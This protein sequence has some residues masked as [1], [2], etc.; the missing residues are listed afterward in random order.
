MVE[1][2]LGDYRRLGVSGKG[3]L[4]VGRRQ[5]GDGDVAR[6]APCRTMTTAFASKEQRLRMAR[7]VSAPPLTVRKRKRC[8]NVVGTAR[9]PVHQDGDSEQ[10]DQ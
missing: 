5:R 3:V 1:V 8:R 7:L 10:R 9:I 6:R 4:S 2:E